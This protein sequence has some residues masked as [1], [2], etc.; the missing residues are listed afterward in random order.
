VRSPSGGLLEIA[1]DT[2]PVSGSVAPP[3]PIW[4]NA[5]VAERSP[6]AFRSMPS[7][8]AADAA[9]LSTTTVTASFAF[10]EGHL[11]V[12]SLVT[13]PDEGY[14]CRLSAHFAALLEGSGYLGYPQHV[15]KVLVS[16]N[17]ALLRRIDKTAKSRGLSRSAYLAG[18]AE[19]DTTRAAPGVTRVARRALS[20]LDE[21]FAG[22]PAEDSTTAIRSERDAR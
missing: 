15:A 6:S 10:A 17:D 1:I 18:L 4:D 2:F 8:R 13:L 19:R 14:S 16:L 20:R 3:M 7:L 11:P 12:G 21:L 22:G 5:R 9:A